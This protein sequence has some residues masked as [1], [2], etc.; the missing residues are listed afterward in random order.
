MGNMR[1]SI[2][3]LALLVG[4]KTTPIPTLDSASK[5]VVQAYCD[6]LQAHLS[7][8][9]DVRNAYYAAD[10]ELRL[11]QVD[12]PG[13]YRQLGDS[14]RAMLHG[15]AAL[16]GDASGR[17]LI[18][19]ATGKLFR[20]T[21]ETDDA[22]LKAHALAL[23]THAFALKHD[24]AEVR[25]VAQ[26]TGG[27]LQSLLMD[28]TYA[29]ISAS[30]A[31]HHDRL[32]QSNRTLPV[33]LRALFEDHRRLADYPALKAEFV[34]QWRKGEESNGGKSKTFEPLQ[35]DLPLRSHIAEAIRFKDRAVQEKASAGNAQV[36]LTNF[37]KALERF[38]F[39]VETAS[40]QDR[41]ENR[42]ALES[43]PMILSEILHLVLADK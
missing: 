3:A 33:R 41:A 26:P 28:M 7:D 35:V 2:V 24:R 38:V 36:V 18:D 43:I 29:K 23:L 4:C 27:P 14:D 39:V 20:V 5:T 11:Y 37:L 19:D 12:A 32:M 9:S 34:D 8:P 22:M 6:Q 16:L 31:H 15:C 42:E 10:L 30:Y 21:Q 17:A 40:S 13:I 25:F 1:I